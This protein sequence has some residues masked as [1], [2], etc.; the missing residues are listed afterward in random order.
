MPPLV[1]CTTLL[2]SLSRAEL[3]ASLGLRSLSFTNCRAMSSQVS[4]LVTVPW[5]K[6][7]IAKK[8]A[9]FQVLDASWH[10]PA[11]NRDAPK[12]FAEK[13]IPT[14]Q[15][16][17]IDAYKSTL[18]TPDQFGKD[19]GALGVG[20]D[21]HVV[22]Y[23][24]NPKFGM[25]SAPR[26]WWLFR[27]FGHENVSIL[28]GGLPKWEEEGGETTA[29]VDQVKPETML[30]TLN[31]ALIRTIEDI[32]ANVENKKFQ[33]VD[34]RPAGRFHGTAPEPRPGKSLYHMYAECRVKIKIP[35]Y[36]RKSREYHDEN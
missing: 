5:L 11:F 36:R 21:T 23:D 27:Y 4:P 17:L 33:V 31:P 18:P 7:A 29:V 22:V 13:H 26:A 15:F 12:E 19:V 10:M 9:K 32:E 25:F 16:F 35:K 24:S 2:R 30:A 34:G 1:L 28:D 20:N 6:E 3:S 14:A 8:S